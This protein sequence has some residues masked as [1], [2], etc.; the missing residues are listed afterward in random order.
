MSAERGNRY[1]NELAIN[2]RHERFTVGQET[3]LEISSK[4]FRAYACPLHRD[5]IGEL[6][7]RVLAGKIDILTFMFG[8]DSHE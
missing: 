8:G 7:F 2:L 3:D 1:F 4:D 6:A 5:G